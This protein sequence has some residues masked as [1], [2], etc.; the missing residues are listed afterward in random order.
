MIR[1]LAEGAEATSSSFPTVVFGAIAFAVFTLLAL[2]TWS[3]RDVANRHKDENDK[4]HH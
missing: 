3:F 1:T 2:V 4:A